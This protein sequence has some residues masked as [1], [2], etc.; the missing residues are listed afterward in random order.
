MIYGAEI[1]SI[2]DRGNYSLQYQS[3]VYFTDTVRWL[4]CYVQKYVTRNTYGQRLKTYV[5]TF[6]SY[7][8]VRTAS[9][10]LLKQIILTFH[11]VL[12]SGKA[13]RTDAGFFG[14]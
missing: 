6:S 14:W 8:Y 5:S 13:A 10:T 2:R 9:N 11:F 4:P 1:H 3:R 12:D 7:S